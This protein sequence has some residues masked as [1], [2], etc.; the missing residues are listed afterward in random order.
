MIKTE[1]CRHKAQQQIIEETIF[2]IYKTP[3]EIAQVP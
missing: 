1:L 2:R 3:L